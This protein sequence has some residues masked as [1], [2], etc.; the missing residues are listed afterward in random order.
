MSWKAG[1][2]ATDSVAAPARHLPGDDHQHRQRR[3]VRRTEVR[4]HEKCTAA[5]RHH[6]PRRLGVHRAREPAAD[7]SLDRHALPLAINAPSSKARFS[8]ETGHRS[9]QSRPLG[10]LLSAGDS[11]RLRF[12]SFTRLLD[13][14]PGALIRRLRGC[15][16]L[17]LRALRGCCLCRCPLGGCWP[18]RCPLRGCGARRLRVLLFGR[19]CGRGGWERWFLHGGRLLKSRVRLV[20]AANQALCEHLLVPDLR[21]VFALTLAPGDFVVIRVHVAFAHVKTGSM[22]GLLRG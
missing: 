11:I 2:C 9:A 17:C 4:A 21:D 5:Q 18:R 14:R 10:D 13:V 7:G 12:L 22:Q 3:Q 16:R 19:R 1:R 8:A 15:S 20:S 6:A